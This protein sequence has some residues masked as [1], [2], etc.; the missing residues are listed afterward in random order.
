MG[1][2]ELL[3]IWYVKGDVTGGGGT[4]WANAFDDLQDALDAAGNGDEIWVAA[5]QEPYVPGTDP[6]Y[7]FQL[8]EGVALYGGFVGGET[9]REDRDWSL[10]ETVLSGDIGVKGD[11]SDNSHHVVVGAEKAIV[12]G[13]TITGGNADGSDP[14]DKGGG[15]YSDSSMTIRRCV[16]SYNSAN[17]GGGLYFAN[18]NPTITDCNIVGNAAASDNGGGLYGSS[19]AAVI[20]GCAIS[21]N[22]ASFS[23][24][25]LYLDGDVSPRLQNCLLANN[26]AGRDGGGISV[27]SDCRPTF[28]NCTIVNNAALG[29]SGPVGNTGFGGGLYCGYNSNSTV[30]NSILW[31]NYALEGHEIAVGTTSSPSILSVSYSNVAGGQSDALVESGCTIN[32]GSGNIS[33]EP[34]F[35]APAINNYHLES[36]SLCIDAGNP[37]SDWSNEPDYPNGQINLGAYGNTSEAATAGEDSDSDRLPD[38]WEEFYWGDGDL[39]HRPLEDTDGDGLRNVEEY[40]LG[41]NPTYTDAPVDI[42]FTVEDIGN[43]QLKISY[44]TYNGARPRSIALS[45]DLGDATIVKNPDIASIVIS[46]KDEYNC[47]M[48]YAHKV[49]ASYSLG[50]GH[51]L[52]APSAA[53]EPDFGGGGVS[54]FSINMVSFDGNQGPGPASANPLVILQLT[55]G[56][57]NSPVVTVSEDTLRNSF[58][59]LVT[60][61]PQTVTVTFGGGS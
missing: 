35:V 30:V 46:L 57:E 17:Q 51:P 7:S 54:Q 45:V 18:C 28:E 61:L 14:D 47:F 56:T 20:S 16:I 24:G 34:Y 13:F 48:D 22:T 49:G 4:S 29:T 37:C 32:W 25:G 41:T 42:K 36:Y 38:E 9:V 3:Q 58:S 23:G 12:D 11:Y 43:G 33:Y 59:N 60:N 39:T 15:V 31:N 21:Q 52:A 8:P 55:Q 1:A 53:G 50:A 40:R 10:N 27:S 6:T 44:V 5:T 19:A 26:T 2:Y